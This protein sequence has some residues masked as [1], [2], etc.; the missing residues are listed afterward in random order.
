MDFTSGLP[1]AKGKDTILVVIDRL[2]KFVHFI[3][4]AHLFTAKE[5]VQVFIREVVR[6]HG[7]PQ[8]IVPDRD[9]L[10]LSRFWAEMF[11]QAGTQLKYSTS[12]H[13]QNDG[14]TEVVNRYLE[15][16]LRCFTSTKPNQWP[17]WL[18][19]AKFWFNT[20][21]NASS[22]MTP[23]QA[24]YGRPPLVVYCGETYPSNVPEVQQ[25]MTGRDQ[26]LDELKEI[27]GW[28]SI[29]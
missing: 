28:P 18:C 8:V 15:M 7:F 14:Q 11:K 1:K 23:F 13:P 9:Q 27:Y 3:A 16:Y 12:Y 29:G 6:L 26:I 22:K 5:V 17:Q 21:Y 10:F 25:L 24:L 19:S 20:T 4:L 2:T